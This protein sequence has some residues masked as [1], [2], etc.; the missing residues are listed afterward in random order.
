VP[1]SFEEI[2]VGLYRQLFN[3][4]A[5]VVK[6]GARCYPVRR[7]HRHHVRQ[8]TSFLKDMMYAAR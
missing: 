1:F 8:V 5:D 2:L 4:N 7:S 3:D 6:L